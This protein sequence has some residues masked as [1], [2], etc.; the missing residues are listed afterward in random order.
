[1]KDDLL[2]QVALTLAPQIG[3]V[4]ARMLV[5]HFG[6]AKAIF[7]AKKK[8]LSMLPNMGDI[9]AKCIKEFTDFSMAEKELSFIEK[10]QI[11]P[12]W[13]KDGAYPKN[14]LHCYDAPILLY[15]KGTVDVNIAPVVSIIGTRSQSE[16][17]RFT[18]ENIIKELKEA[19]VLVVSGLAAGIDAT[20][21]KSA[22]QSG[23]STVGV[24]AHGMQTVYPHQ[25]KGL[26]KDM[27]QQGGLITE[28]TQFE[29]PEKHNFPRR[30]RIVA[31]MADAVV[32]IETAIKGGSMITAELAA[33]YNRDVFAIPGRLSDQRSGGCNYLIKSNKAILLTDG[34]QLLENMGWLKKKKQPAVQ[35]SLFPDLSEDEKKIVNILKEK[36]LTHIDEI[37]ARLGLAGSSIASALL[38]LELISAIIALPGKMYRLA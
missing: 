37:H 26:A 11:K 34:T 29:K 3:P 24:L 1:M 38:N 36:D 33:N 10:Y 9:R 21:H 12:L 28:F 22:L 15:Y 6:S 19:G 13:I 2:Y 16:Y 31:G 7:E 8:E 27:M 14:L 23:L 5:E 30:N 25:H 18:T 4:Q 20:A 35:R 32:V 17:G